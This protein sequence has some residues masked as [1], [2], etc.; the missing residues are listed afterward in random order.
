MDKTLKALIAAACIVVI[1]GGGYFA[2]SE[3]RTRQVT[4]ARNSAVSTA[5][6][7]QARKTSLSKD[8]CSILAT[9]ALS[10]VT[11]EQFRTPERM[12]D[13]RTCFQLD[14]LGYVERRDL[15]DA[16]LFKE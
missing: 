11:G 2:W 13:L 8:A 7:E 10:K 16:G 5:A 4:T 9:S 12:A 14:R 1:A 6:Q 3:Y 15:V